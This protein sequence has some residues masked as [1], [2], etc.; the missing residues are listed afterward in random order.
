MKIKIKPFLYTQCI[1]FG[2]IIIANAIMI[3]TSSAQTPAGKVVFTQGT[4]VAVNGEGTERGLARGNDIYSGDRLITNAGRLQLSM[5]D[6]AFISVQPNS[7]YQ[8]E[9]Y[10]YSGTPDGTE[11]ANYRLVKGGIRAVTGLIGR[12]NPEAYKVNTAVATIGIRGTGHNTRICAGDC[13]SRED[14]LYHQTW[15]GI[16]FVVNDVDT[17]DVPTGTGVYVADI[18]T[19]IEVLDQPPAVLAVETIR[20]RGG[21]RTEGI[22]G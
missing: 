15:E 19:D 5:V 8:V 2:I 6:G 17:E 11:I 14:G 21:S 10:N 4:P 3:Q 22:R 9:N 18:D 20:E 12:Q 16:T 7:E 1:N 13:G